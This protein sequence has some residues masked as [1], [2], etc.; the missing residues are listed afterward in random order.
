MSE[1]ALIFVDVE[2]TGTRATRDRIT[3]IAA[4]KVVNGEVVDRWSSL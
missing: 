3:E 4:L 2:T 1:T